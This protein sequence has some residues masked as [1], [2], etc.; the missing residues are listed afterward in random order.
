M[1]E[2][3]TRHAR[4]A[5]VLAREEVRELRVREIAPQ[6]LLLGILQSADDELAAVLNGYGLTAHAVRARLIECA[7]KTDE[8]FDE[9]AEVLRAIGID[10]GA[11]RDSVARTFGPDAF[12][13]ALSSVGATEPPAALVQPHP[14]HPSGQE[15]AGVRAA[16]SL[17]PQGQRDRLRA[18]AAGH[19]AQRRQ[20]RPRLDHRARVHGAAAR[21]DPRPA[22]QGRLARPASSVRPR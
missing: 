14:V 9:D 4:A 2:R 6:H 1:F 3:F 11:V 15:D 13:N 19:S 16:R 12:D 5:V 21:G 7:P 17:D 18:S 10:L 22:G 8:A 20:G